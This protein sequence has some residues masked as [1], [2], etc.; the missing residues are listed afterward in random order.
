[1]LIAAVLQWFDMFRI[2]CIWKVPANILV[3]QMLYLSIGTVLRMEAFRSTSLLQWIASNFERFTFGQWLSNDSSYPLSLSGGSCKPPPS[4]GFTLK[5][6]FDGLE[7]WILNCF[8]EAKNLILS[9]FVLIDL[10]LS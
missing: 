10:D 3:T 5:V 2:V 9:F 6:H 4:I 8:G 7:K 1:M